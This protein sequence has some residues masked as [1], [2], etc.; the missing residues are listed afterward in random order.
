VEEV[1]DGVEEDEGVGLV[2]LVVVD[3]LRYRSKTRRIARK[4]WSARN[5]LVMG[6]DTISPQKQENC[7]A[8]Q[9][10][11]VWETKECI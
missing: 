10:T 3:S 8:E 2:E 1:V 7:V 6:S 11:Y 9:D 4:S 5:R